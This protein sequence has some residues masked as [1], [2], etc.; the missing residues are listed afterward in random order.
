MVPSFWWLVAFF[1]VFL[2]A[3]VAIGLG[4]ATL[5]RWRYRRPGAPIPSIN[6]KVIINMTWRQLLQNMTIVTGWLGVFVLWVAG[7]ITLQLSP[8]LITL[9]VVFLAMFPFVISLA[10]SSLIFWRKRSEARKQYGYLIGQR[11]RVTG[12]EENVRAEI[13]ITYAGR[14]RVEGEEWKEG[15]EILVVDVL[16]EHTLRARRYHPSEPE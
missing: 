9:G 16:D 11:L 2:A 12:V 8:L 5:I 3:S 10:R 14:W 15:D 13:V 6:E 1:A 4:L 7:G